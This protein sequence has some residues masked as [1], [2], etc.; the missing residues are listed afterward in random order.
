MSEKSVNFVPDNESGDGI[1]YTTTCDNLLTQV[2]GT[3]STSEN[4][5]VVDSIDSADFPDDLSNKSQKTY[6][7]TDFIGNF[8]NS[9]GYSA[10]GVKNDSEGAE[11][12]RKVIKLEIPAESLDFEEKLI[13]KIGNEGDLK[14]LAE[15]SSISAETVLSDTF[16][17]NFDLEA[18]CSTVCENF[19][20]KCEFYADLKDLTATLRTFRTNLSTLIRSARFSSTN[21]RILEFF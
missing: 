6:K 5:S 12:A 18:T 13:D 4:N 9:G 7:N 15:K 11:P 20:R 8:D 17:P 21:A 19:S 14:F 1:Y 2:A 16:E 10:F 3:N